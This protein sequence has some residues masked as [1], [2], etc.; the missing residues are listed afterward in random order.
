MASDKQEAK[1]EGGRKERGQPARDSW[2]ANVP[3]SGF[4]FSPIISSRLES[5]QPSFHYYILFL[6]S[7]PSCP[8][9][10]VTSPLLPARRL[11][12]HSGQ[13]DHRLRPPRGRGFAR[14]GR[15]GRERKG[16]KEREANG[17]PSRGFIRDA[18]RVF[19]RHRSNF[20]MFRSHFSNLRITDVDQLRAL[21]L[22]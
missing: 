9:S 4:Q 1:G 18:T 16:E 7:H 14:I 20:S 2:L 8:F 6:L 22:L 12:K 15:R 21:D 17:I 5:R 3:V 11:I 13:T 10:P 19:A